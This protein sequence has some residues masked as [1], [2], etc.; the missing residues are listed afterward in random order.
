MDAV[1][2]HDT[3]MA[4][5]VKCPRA[6]GTPTERKQWLLGCLYIGIVALIWTFSSILVQY[7]FEE[8]DFNQPFGEQEIGRRTLKSR[9][10][11]LHRQFPVC[12]IPGW[13]VYPQEVR[14]G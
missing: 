3:P 8:L 13:L 6:A 11:D 9:S 10:S 4:E 5:E 14:Y 2:V 7:I 1:G 12:D